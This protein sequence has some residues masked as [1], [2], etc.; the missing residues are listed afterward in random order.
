MIRTTGLS[1]IFTQDLESMPEFAIQSHTAIEEASVADDPHYPYE[2]SGNEES[3]EGAEMEPVP[4]SERQI[5]Y[6]RD[7]AMQNL[8][9]GAEKEQYMANIESLSRSDCS[10]AIKGM[11]A[12]VGR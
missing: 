5:S 3:E 4:A 12:M 8:D 1:D 11:L 6:L 10:E 2:R 9:E 7:L